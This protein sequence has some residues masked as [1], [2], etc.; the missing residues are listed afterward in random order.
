MP[1]IG[2]FHLMFFAARDIPLGDRML[3]VAVAGGA[4]AAKRWPVARAVARGTAAGP[5]A[6]RLQLERGWRGSCRVSDDA[7]EG[8]VRRSLHEADRF[9]QAAAPVE[10]Q[11]GVFTSTTLKTFSAVG[12][13]T[14]GCPCTCAISDPFSSVTVRSSRLRRRG[15]CPRTSAASRG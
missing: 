1:G 11:R 13:R 2:V 7:R 3:A 12:T 8:E 4:V 6:P 15:K 5:S 9:D 10:G 14:I